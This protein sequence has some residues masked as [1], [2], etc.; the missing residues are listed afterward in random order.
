MI[1]ALVF[2]GVLA[3]L[4]IA[5]IAFA[6]PLNRKLSALRAAREEIASLAD[7]FAAATAKAQ[8]GL[9]EM[10]GLA[11]ESGELLERRIAQAR[12]VRDELAFLLERAPGIAKRL[13]R[14]PAA[15]E[16]AAESEPEVEER[17]EAP[18]GGRAL[19]KALQ[20]LR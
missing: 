18:P 5:L 10:R 6:V 3:A 19:F 15:A 9:G 13:E 8:S 17:G 2:D 1:L 20:G 16:A 12:G 4:L 11:E 14:G 7:R